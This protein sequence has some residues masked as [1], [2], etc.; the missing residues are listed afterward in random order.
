MVDGT[1]RVFA[2]PRYVMSQLGHTNATFTFNVYTREIDRRDGE[3]ER[4]KALVQGAQLG[5]I[6]QRMDSK[7]VSRDSGPPT[8]V[9]A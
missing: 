2:L 1:G 5:S 6:G 9:A 7:G 4:L 8:A 3:P